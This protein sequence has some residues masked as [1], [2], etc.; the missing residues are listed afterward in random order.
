VA[1]VAIVVV[2]ALVGAFLLGRR[3]REGRGSSPPPASNPSP[4]APPPA[5][6]WSEEESSGPANRGR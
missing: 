5:P 6:A 2:A 4:G 1:L 3:G